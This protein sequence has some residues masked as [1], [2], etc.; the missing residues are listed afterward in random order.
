VSYNYTAHHVEK[1]CMTKHAE[2]VFRLKLLVVTLKGK[3][4]VLVQN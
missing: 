3:L 2:G 4:F 1:V